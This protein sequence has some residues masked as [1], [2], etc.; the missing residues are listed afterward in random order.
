MNRMWAVAAA[1]VMAA[2]V[3]VQAGPHSCTPLVTD[4]R[5][6]AEDGALGPRADLDVVSADFATSSDDSTVIA[7]VR[8]ASLPPA[9]PGRPVPAAGYHLRLQAGDRSHLATAYRGA[10]GEKFRF[11]SGILSAQGPPD[12][13]TVA[14]AFDTARG[15]VRW[16]LPLSAFNDGSRALRRGDRVTGVSVS[17]LEVYGVSEAYTGPAVD[18]TTGSKTYVI[19]AAGCAQR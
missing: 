1:M 3:P 17:V 15:L 13:R 8:V 6:D 7:T 14:G 12:V 9:A 5:G 10:D 2:A 19:G 11:Q 18:E 4:Q 16:E